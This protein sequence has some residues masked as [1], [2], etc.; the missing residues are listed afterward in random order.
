M[1]ISILMCQMLWHSQFLATLYRDVCVCVC[2][3]IV[4]TKNPIR[5]RSNLSSEKKNYFVKLLSKIHR[6]IK[7]NQRKKRE[8]SRI[9][10]QLFDCCRCW[11]F[12][13]GSND[14]F[15]LSICILNTLSLCCFFLF[16]L[17]EEMQTD[18]IRTRMIWIIGT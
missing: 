15:F 5:N 4:A 3:D 12:V 11:Q 9:I 13:V 10:C 18:V 14:T 6:K 1:H 2:S 8:K 16:C 7:K 17:L